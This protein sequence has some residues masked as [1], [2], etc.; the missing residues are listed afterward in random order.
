MEFSDFPELNIN[1]TGG[2]PPIIIAIVVVIVIIALY[3]LVLK[4]EPEK[5][6]KVDCVYEETVTESNCSEDCGPGKKTKTTTYNITTQ[7]AHGGQ[8][9][10]QDKT[11]EINCNVKPCPVDCVYEET[12]TES[13]CSEDCGPGKKTK[14][15]TYNITTQAAHGGQ[16]CPQDKTEEI[17]CNVKPC[18]VDCDYKEIV[19]ESKCS[20][21][22]NKKTKTTTYNITTQ[23]AHGGKACPQ[24]KTEQINCD[25]NE[26]NLIQFQN[27]YFIGNGI[28]K[29]Y[30]LY[31]SNNLDLSGDLTISFFVKFNNFNNRQN[32]IHKNFNNEFS[33]TFEKS[34]RDDSSFNFYHGDGTNYDTFTISNT[35]IKVN[36]WIK[37]SII[38][39][40]TEKTIEFFINEQS[41]KK[42]TYKKNIGKSTDL[43][44]IGHGYTNPIDGE[45]KN[46]ILKNKKLSI[47]EINN[48][49]KRQDQEKEKI[50]L[51]LQEVEEKEIILD[52]PNETWKNSFIEGDKNFNYLENILL[53]NNLD[54]LEDFTISFFIKKNNNPFISTSRY[55][56]R[57][58]IGFTKEN[59]DGNTSNNV[60]HL[61][62]GFYGNEAIENKYDSFVV[63]YSFEEP[64][65]KD[66]FLDPNL[67]YI[68]RH[69]LYSSGRINN[70]YQ[71]IIIKRKIE[72]NKQFIYLY[73]DN[74]KIKSQ[75]PSGF[76]YKLKDNTNYKY[77]PITNITNS[78]KL[79]INNEY[80]DIK[81]IKIFK[82]ALDESEI[83]IL[84]L[85]QTNIESFSNTNKLIDHYP[86]SGNTIN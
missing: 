50:I 40:N 56:R 35:K 8:A 74:K 12:V 76:N 29:G 14:T 47:D 18:P 77:Y 26:C 72:N 86:V 78:N 84:Y 54:K 24:T 3:F 32:P 20:C 25:I 38:R 11:E 46:L 22:T 55:A 69:G 33:V 30:D 36:E 42:D 10:P 57:P 67:W 21:G 51:D 23:A 68:N 85:N 73:I 27:R 15:T 41:I 71:H 66:E 64:K 82:T 44:K 53:D 6:E 83:S 65:N 59:K 75:E 34:S 60:N 17:E 19:T 43:L 31:N 7:A 52:L 37:I 45:L 2:S 9:C 58:V 62:L 61:S 28:K 70:E 63:D 81:N 39:D 48:I 79:Y 1:Q 16:A 13:N 80:S 4:K 49:H 5:K